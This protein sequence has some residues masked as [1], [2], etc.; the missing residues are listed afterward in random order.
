MKTIIAAAAIALVFGS[1]ASA[2]VAVRGH[3]RSDGTYVAPHYRSSPN[4]TTTDNYSTRPNVNPYTGAVG[5]RDPYAPQSSARAPQ[6]LYT[7]PRPAPAPVP[8]GSTP[9]PRCTGYYC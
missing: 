1:A 4:S 3:T 6:S 8:F 9:R 2:Q 5:T 7:P